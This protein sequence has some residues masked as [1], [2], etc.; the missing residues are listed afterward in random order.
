M[1]RIF[2]TLDTETSNQAHTL[3]VGKGILADFVRRG[4]EGDVIAV[5]ASQAARVRRLAIAVR[6]LTSGVPRDVWARARGR[7]ASTCGSTGTA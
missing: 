6:A 3:L 2:F 5:P 7:S 1:K 4:A